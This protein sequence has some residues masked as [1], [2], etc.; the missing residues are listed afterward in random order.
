MLTTSEYKELS[1]Q[2]PHGSHSRY[3]AHLLA[4]EEACDP[5]REA[6]RIY[7]AKLRARRL[8]QD[9]PEQPRRH[10]FARPASPGTEV[11]EIEDEDELEDDEE[12]YE[13]DDAPP[14]GSHASNL[15][16]TWETIGK[17]GGLFGFLK[18]PTS[19]QSTLAP[20]SKRKQST[21]LEGPKARL[22]AISAEVRAPKLRGPEAVSRLVEAAP[23]LT[24][25]ANALAQYGDGL[26]CDPEDI[27]AAKRI[28]VGKGKG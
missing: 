5:C 6:E 26:G 14:A 12:E 23:Y 4:G 19:P 17:L 8:D 18:P 20:A 22:G 21:I 9:E 28:V 15:A 2:V 1:E 24:G 16:Q 10:S 13:P 25:G 3:N 27:A 11:E 7:R